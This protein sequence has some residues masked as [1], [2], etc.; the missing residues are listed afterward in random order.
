MYLLIDECCGKAL[1]RVSEELGHTAQRTRDVP[2]LGQGA[3]DAEIYQFACGAG[4]HI[5]TANHRDL[6]TLAAASGPHPGMIFVPP[7]LGV[8]LARLFKAVLPIAEAEF[9]SGPNRIVEAQA[10]GTI[11]SYEV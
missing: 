5:V 7:L 2:Q 8:A 3:S 11:R 9:S 1:V 10:D 6:E 4:A